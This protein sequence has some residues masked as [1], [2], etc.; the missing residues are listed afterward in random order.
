MMQFCRRP[1]NGQPMFRALVL[2]LLFLLLLSLPTASSDPTRSNMDPIIILSLDRKSAEV[3]VSPDSSGSVHFNL[4]VECELPGDLPENATCIVNLTAYAWWNVTEIDTM[5]FSGNG[6]IRNIEI[7]VDVPINTP[8]EADHDLAITGGW[9][10]RNLSLSGSLQS[11]SASI[12]VLP[13]YDLRMGSN[14]PVKY[15]R[16]GDRATFPFQ[17]TNRANGDINV[18]LRIKRDPGVIEYWL[19]EQNIF[20]KKGET[21]SFNISFR[22]TPSASRRNDLHLI[23]VIDEEAEGTEYVLDLELR[24]DPTLSTFFYERNFIFLVAVIVVISVIAG[25]LYIRERVH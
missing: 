13:F 20:L 17:M 11:I 24:T 25:T 15:V 8:A 5:V 14:E 23:A 1:R 21:K 19:D 22:Q 7:R 3:K 10:Y 9:S 16:V 18:T 4:T 2:S 6:G 12:D